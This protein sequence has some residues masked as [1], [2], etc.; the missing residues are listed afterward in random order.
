[1]EVFGEA[2]VLL[3]WFGFI[4]KGFSDWYFLLGFSCFFVDMQV[5]FWFLLVLVGGINCGLLQ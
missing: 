1:M 5:F 3:R 4:R 2:K